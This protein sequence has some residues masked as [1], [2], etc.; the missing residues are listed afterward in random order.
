MAKLKLSD[1]LPRLATFALPR[2]QSRRTFTHHIS[3][4]SALGSG[5]VDASWRCRNR[6][7]TKVVLALVVIKWLK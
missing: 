4:N 5:F 2:V 3:L 6:F 7:T 1:Q